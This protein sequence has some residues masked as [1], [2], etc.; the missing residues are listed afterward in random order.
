[1]HVNITIVN[2]D[3]TLAALLL[4]H[5]KCC[6]YLIAGSKCDT[7]YDATKE[8]LEPKPA[9]AEVLVEVSSHCPKVTSYDDGM[10]VH[11]HMY[12]HLYSLSLS[13]Y[14]SFSLLLSP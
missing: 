12:T 13:L 4:Y 11:T 1:M 7:Y 6:N 14:L 9:I 10:Y 3:L 8:V 2:T 5:P